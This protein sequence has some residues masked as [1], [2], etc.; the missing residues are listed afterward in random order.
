MSGFTLDQ[1]NMATMLMEHVVADSCASLNTAVD[2]DGLPLLV[3]AKAGLDSIFRDSVE[4]QLPVEILPCVR[5]EYAHLSMSIDA[6]VG[7]P[8]ESRAT[9]VS[10]YILYY[11]G[12]IPTDERPYDFNTL[13][14]RHI[15]A[16]QQ[17]LR[18][19]VAGNTQGI[20]WS[21]NHWRWATEFGVDIDCDTPFKYLD[22]SLPIGDDR[23]CVR[24]DYYV[25]GN[26]A[27][28]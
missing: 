4:G 3:D 19:Q 14:N 22:Y 6:N 25:K 7:G 21:A 16:L 9:R 24:M 10:F 5:V 1:R 18:F 27:V 13:R 28:S 15:W 12:N 2:I 23:A 17:Y 11:R 8:V 20:V 26:W